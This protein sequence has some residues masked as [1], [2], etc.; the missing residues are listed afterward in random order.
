MTMA[1]QSI[2][3]ADISAFVDIPTPPAVKKY[4]LALAGQLELTGCQVVTNVGSVGMG[5]AIPVVMTQGK[6]V[7]TMKIATSILAAVLFTGTLGALNNAI[8]Q[9]GILS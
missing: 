7:R 2:R 3:A 5:L 8:A 1:A 4:L 9:D 6:E